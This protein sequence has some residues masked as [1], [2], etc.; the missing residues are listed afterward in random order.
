MIVSQWGLEFEGGGGGTSRVLLHVAFLRS[1]CISCSI[2]WLTEP[3]HTIRHTSSHCNKE[4]RQDGTGISHCL[5]LKVSQ[6]FVATALES[7][8]KQDA[9]ELRRWKSR[10]AHRMFRDPHS[11]AYACILSFPAHPTA[12][13]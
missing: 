12:F 3:W 13:R 2:S 10:G 11:G 7:T 8:S 9:L 5:Y 4:R 1:V 6:Y